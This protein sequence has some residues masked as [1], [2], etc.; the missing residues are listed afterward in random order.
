MFDRTRMTYYPLRERKN[1][2]YIENATIDSDKDIFPLTDKQEVWIDTLCDEILEA[3]GTGRPVILAFGAHT[4]KN[5][6]GQLLGRFAREG[7]FTHL[8]TN[9]AGII[10]DWEFAYQGRSSE[11]VKANVAEGKFGTWEETGRYLNL[12]LAI[13][14]YEGCGYGES[15]GKMIEKDGVM[16]PTKEALRSI[17]LDQETSLEKRGSA[18]DL[19]DLIIRLDLQ[20]GWLS[21]DHPYK[22]YSLQQC[23]YVNH[24]RFTSHPMF[25]H[26]IIY[27]HKAN[28]GSVIGRTAERDF[29]TFVDSIARLEGGVYLSVGSAVMSPMIFEKALSMV[30]NTGVHIN[31]AIIRVVDLQEG[32][33]DWNKGEPPESDPAYYQRFMKTFSRMGLK[34][35]YLSIDNR[36]LFVNLY[37]A[38][39][40]KG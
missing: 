18:L 23:A 2:V 36:S 13:G 20:P 30:R 28:K 1:K 10:H 7:Y 33:W 11:D 37:T 12:A 39:K 19:L 22:A 31:D 32:S 5:G 29:L 25:G 14:S 34:S 9:G 17:S 8:A 16:I 26:D 3:R 38:L 21:I 35:H 40:R 4:I 15:V 6:L 24:V 27:T